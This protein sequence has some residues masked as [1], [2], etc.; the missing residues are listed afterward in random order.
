M[1][2]T[3]EN[4]IDFLKEI[5]SELVNDGIENVMNFF[6]VDLSVRMNTNVRLA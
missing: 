6:E 3:K 1:R 4:I 5:K 2:A